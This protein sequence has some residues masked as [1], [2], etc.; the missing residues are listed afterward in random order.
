[1]RF[2]DRDADAA[3]L[4]ANAPKIDAHASDPMPNLVIK[5]TAQRAALAASPTGL[6]HRPWPHR[7]IEIMSAIL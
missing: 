1:M 2:S 4:D 5:K 7:S 6:E 3:K